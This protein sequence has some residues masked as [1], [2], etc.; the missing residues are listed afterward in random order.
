[1]TTTIPAQDMQDQPLP[2][3]KKII[4]GEYVAKDTS[5]TTHIIIKTN[6][7][8]ILQ[9]FREGKPYDETKTKW[10]IKND[11]LYI[12]PKNLLSIPMVFVFSK[13]GMYDI[14]AET[15][16]HRIAIMNGTK[17]KKYFVKIK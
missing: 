17:K 14:G 8:F 15:S 4:T 11:T 6:H 10:E 13:N 7:D 5:V 9:Q 12:K 3:T 1:M 16:S 2:I